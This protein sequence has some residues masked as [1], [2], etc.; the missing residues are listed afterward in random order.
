MKALACV[1]LAAMVS[2]ARPAAAQAN[3][4]LLPDAVGQRVLYRVDGTLMGSNGPQP[5]ATVIALV[6]QDGARFLVVGDTTQRTPPVVQM[7]GDG[8]LALVEPQ[9]GAP[10]ANLA[11]M[12]YAF[13]LALAA[14]ANIA[15]SVHDAW[16]A[17]M[18]TSP[19]PGAPTATVAL[20]P[21]DVAGSDFAFRGSGEATGTGLPPASPS[22][23]DA[24]RGRGGGADEAAADDDNEIITTVRV[25]G[26]VSGGRVTHVSVVETRSSLALP[27][28][29][30]PV[31]SW[32][33]TILKE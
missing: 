7:V 17:D 8:A 21:V 23:R 12:V 4:S 28:A 31:G 30:T 25:E 6:R 29:P 3:I 2:A 9:A 15:Q 22:P 26:Q 5:T 11:A 24:R 19:A 1:L 16:Q 18:P 27:G 33:V 14:T 20:F 32:S 13:N 10:D